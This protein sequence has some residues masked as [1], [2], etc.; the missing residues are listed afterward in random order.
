M[1]ENLIPQ[2]FESKIFMETRAKR[3]KIC[4]LARPTY[5]PFARIAV[6]SQ[7]FIVNRLPQN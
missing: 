4:A 7:K 6:S 1:L 2:G 3:S 5:H